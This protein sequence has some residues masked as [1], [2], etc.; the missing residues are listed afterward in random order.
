MAVLFVIGLALGGAM[1]VVSQ[2]GL[3]KRVGNAIERFTAYSE[4][5]RELAILNGE[6]VGLVL[7]PPVWRDNPI[8][9]GWRYSWQTLTFEG[10]KEIE[11]MPATEFDPEVELAVL[12]EEE[13]WEYKPNEKPEI[14]LPLIAFYPGGDVTPFEIEFSHKDDLEFSEHVEVDVWG[15]VVWREKAKAMEEIKDQ[16]N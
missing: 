9:D 1:L 13:L 4:H 2:G 11:G 15:N 6:P 16:F 5:A 10:W 12:I 3:Q 8:T 7:E 14:I